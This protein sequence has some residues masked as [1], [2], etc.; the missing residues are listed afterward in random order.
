MLRTKPAEHGSEEVFSFRSYSNLMLT[1]NGHLQYCSR[2][3]LTL[4]DFEPKYFSHTQT[5]L[6]RPWRKSE[7]PNAS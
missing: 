7:R 4:A 5:S 6:K 3:F 1:R 2:A